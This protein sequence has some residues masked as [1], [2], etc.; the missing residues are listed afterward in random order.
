[1]KLKNLIVI[2][3]LTFCF[4]P[5]VKAQEEILSSEISQPVQGQ[6]IIEFSDSEESV[7]TKAD[8]LAKKHGLKNLHVYKNVLKGANVIVP[9][10][11]EK[12]LINDSDIKRV[13]QDFTIS[14]FGKPTMDGKPSMGGG[15]TTPS[16]IIPTGINW[17]DAELNTTN[18]GSGVTVAVLDTGID[19]DHPDLMVN[20]PLSRD[21]TTDGTG[22]DDNN[23][24]IKGHGTHCAGI[25]AAL[26]NSIGVLGVG[27]QIDLVAVKV[28]DRTGSGTFGWIIAGLDYVIANADVIGVT[29]SSFGARGGTSP[30]QGFLNASAL[31]HDAYIRAANAGV[32]NV[33]AAGNDAVD[34]TTN[35]VV[36]AMYPE[37]ITVSALDDR[38]GT[39]SVDKWASFSNFGLEVDVIAPGVK[40]LSTSNDGKTSAL[41]GTSFSA[42]HV[43]G[44]VGLYIARN[45]RPVN[46][47]AQL[48]GSL[49]SAISNPRTTLLSGEPNDSF[50][51]P[52]CYA[53]GAA[54][55]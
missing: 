33:V 54:L 43:A 42:P 11:K 3:V 19:F 37:V 20:I 40:I 48:L 26:D 13:V 46:G 55:Q 23:N 16:Q 30:S 36:P 50:T 32:I 51:E 49:L 9:P 53:N 45:T 38:D 17:I 8:K 25:I 31:L 10:G 4:L 12:D 24:Q 34:V 29:N 15:S 47:D 27:S 44:T 6:Y 39:T 5:G 21:F 18:E 22:G 14:A 41:S 2:A 7:E 28:L 35:N 52:S 1:M